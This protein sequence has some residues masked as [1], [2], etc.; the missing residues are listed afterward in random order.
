MGKLGSQLARWRRGGMSAVLSA[1]GVK[2]AQS[3]ML[4]IRGLQTTLDETKEL[5]RKAFEMNEIV[6]K[7]FGLGAPVRRTEDPRLIKGEGRYV[8]DE[9]R[10]GALHAYVMRAPVAHGLFTMGDLTAARSAKGVHLIMTAADVTDYGGLTAD[11]LPTQLDGSKPSVD[12]LPL[13]CA[14][15]VRHVG[16]AIAFI[17][18]E[19]VDEAKSAAELIDVDYEVAAATVGAET[20]MADGAPL[21]WA[22]KANNIG[23]H[24]FYGDR[25]AT[26]RAFDQAA[27]VVELKVVN[28]R[29]VANYLE[30][31]GCVAAYDPE[32]GAFE[33]TVGSQGVHGM[34]DAIAGHCLKIDPA[35]LHVFTHDVGGGF[36]TKGFAYRE[37][38]LALIAAKRLGRVVRWVCERNEHFQVDA[39]G[40]DNITTGVLAF[41]ADYK[42]TAM[43]VDLIAD[44]GAYAH[45]YGMYIPVLGVTMTT[46]LYDIPNVAVDVRGVYTHTTPTDAYRGAGRPEAT[47]LI[48]RMMDHAARELGLS[49]IDLRRRNFI[50]PDQLPYTTAMGRMYDTGEFEGHM[51]RALDL[52]DVAGFEARLATSKA[53]GHIR[54]LGIATYIEACAFAGSEEATVRLDEDGGVTFLIGTQSNGQGH[55]TA[56]GQIVAGYLGLDLDQ[57]RMVQGDTKQVR[58]GGGT[59]A[60]RSVPL[61]GAS[62]DMA[63]RAL[64]EQIKKLAAEELEAGEGDLELD[65]GEVRVVGTDKRVSLADLAANTADKDK[66][67]AIGE[68]KQNEATYP[69]GTHICEVEIDPLTGRV[70][71]ATYTIVDDFG[72]T[73]NPLLLQGQ[74]H[75]GAMQGIGQALLERTVYSD[76]GQLN[77]AS[78]LDYTMPRADDFVAIVFETRNV[79]STTNM[80]GIKGAGEAATIGAT[81]AVMNAVVDALNRAY[82]IK[83][84]DMPA[85]PDRVWAAIQKACS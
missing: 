2:R 55:H 68:F 13:L 51:D 41:D 81:P 39:H 72:V 1:R 31:R 47:Y 73:V 16:D 27:H 76:D 58:V 64:V 63:S 17:V 62:V 37:Y 12:P 42:I 14:D 8:A 50:T 74:V 23:F 34:R 10:A 84:L 75:G 70:A 82:G 26:D 77:S 43:K 80:L 69:N 32:T 67:K 71:L 61:G 18:A 22:D 21:V 30:P 44:L 53:S 46:G 57:V 28:Q 15:R 6:V 4:N 85:T 65:S 48:E 54:G 25:G 66:L 24:S 78:F 5:K 36:G 83:D 29:L 9:Q 19:S 20:A 60:S 38:P 3:Y 52:A 79:P 40:R 45:A 33:L 7:K 56:Y 11:F 59:G 35:N 49:R